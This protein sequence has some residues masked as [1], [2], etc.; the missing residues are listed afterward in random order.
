MLPHAFE[1]SLFS[2]F[3]LKKLPNFLKNDPIEAVGC[4]AVMAP[5]VGKMEGLHLNFLIERMESWRNP[6]KGEQK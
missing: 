3:G 4:S 2:F 6:Q 1:I 5:K